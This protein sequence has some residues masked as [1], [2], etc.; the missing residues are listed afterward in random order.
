[1]IYKVLCSEDLLLCNRLSQTVVT[2]HNNNLPCK[3]TAK[4]LLPSAE[5]DGLWNLENV[6]PR[7]LNCL[8]HKLALVV[9]W[10]FSYKSWRGALDS[11][12]MGTS[13]RLSGLPLNVVVEF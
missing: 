4:E 12:H 6:L 3:Q 5:F 2:W 10:E 1:M 9:H 13:T 8:I 11:I 7:L